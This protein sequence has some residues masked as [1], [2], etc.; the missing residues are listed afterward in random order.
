MSIIGKLH[1]LLLHFP[2]ALVI[3]AA[4]VELVAVLTRRAWWRAFAVASLRAGAAT[5]AITAVTGWALAATPVAEPSHLLEWH[6][7]AGV[8]AAAAAAAAALVAP[9]L[10][11]ASARSVSLYQVLLFAAAALVGAAGHLGGALVWGADFFRL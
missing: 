4:A 8:S 2:I 10:G 6:R 3:A 11:A 1:P 5:A 7:W 9:R